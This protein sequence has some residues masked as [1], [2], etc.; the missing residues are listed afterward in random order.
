MAARG[1]VV[2]R[3]GA[4]SPLLEAAQQQRPQIVA[5]R[6][7]DRVLVAD[8]H[9]TVRTHIR[10]S[11]N[12]KRAVG[13][14]AQDALLAA[15]EKVIHLAQVELHKANLQRERP[16]HRCC[17]FHSAVDGTDL[18]EKVLGGER[19]CDGGRKHSAVV[20]VHAKQPIE[21][22]NRLMVAAVLICVH[23]RGVALSPRKEA[24]W[25]T[26]R[27]STARSSGEA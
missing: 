20:C 18:I 23:P 5:G 15:I 22:T 13:A 14:F 3:G 10:G 26:S 6:H 24:V 16:V 17:G 4:H 2:H 8:E 25:L 1:L 12:M 11:A 19:R 27:A 9:A 7:F 21:A